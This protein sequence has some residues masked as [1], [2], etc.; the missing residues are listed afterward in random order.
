MFL[1]QAIGSDFDS[2][3]PMDASIVIDAFAASSRPVQELVV[4]LR[5]RIAEE[6]A[7][8]ELTVDYYRIG[9]RL[10]FPLPLD[11]RPQ[12]LPTGIPQMTAYPW[13]TWLFWELE[14]RWRLLSAGWRHLNDEE[15]GRLLQDEVSALATWSHFRG[16]DDNVSLI[17]GHVAAILAHLLSHPSD[18]DANSH[19]QIHATAIDMMERDL[20]PW[21]QCHWA[22]E[23]EFTPVKLHNIA[24]ISLVR[25]AHLA[26]ML[27]HPA[28]TQLEKR[29][30][31]AVRSWWRFRLDDPPHSEGAA[32][33]GY[34]MDHVTEWLFS[35]P[36]GEALFAEGLPAF[37]SL[38]TQWIQLALPG[39]LAESAPLGDV[40]SEMPFWMTVL[41]R[42]AVA[43]AGQVP[44]DQGRWLVQRIAP[45]RLPAAALEW[46]LVN[47]EKL[48]AV[49]SCPSP[50]IQPLATAVTVRTGWE[51]EDLL[52][53]VAAS[54]SPMSHLHNDGGQM[55]LGW[56]G[57][58]WIT[59]PGY[60]QYRPG[61]ERG[62]TI[63]IA[64]HN[65]PVFDDIAQ[66]RRNV[67][68]TTVSE[69]GDSRYHLALD[70]SGCYEGL[71][72]STQIFRDFWMNTEGKSFTVVVRDSFHGLQPGCVIKT[73]WL[74]AADL[75]WSFV[76]NWARLSDGERVLWMGAQPAPFTASQLH[77]HPGSRG[78]L[79]LGH[80][81]TLPNGN[82]VHWWIFQSGHANEWTPSLTQLP[83][84][85]P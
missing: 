44:F 33:D 8:A 69:D 34:L 21:F 27:D 59:D 48:T 2:R 52:L 25:G 24:L 46:L 35:L 77:R 49:P 4:E 76:D 45:V 26:R 62:Y 40:E 11:R 10:S 64:A 30:L 19:Q 53:V 72:A 78:P 28:T 17:T 61:E 65:P 31:D 23:D 36:Q 63:G 60:Q 50:G 83:I 79:T 80:T 38:A 42:L 9:H 3:L 39:D 57:R 7:R 73:H 14:T 43:Y 74:A 13:T 15:A 56:R 58:F 85:S 12:G 68:Q 41:C 82:G 37:A 67:K 5:K 20:L 71:P 16:D 54:R 84:L 55:L 47:Q 81:N 32:Y 66:T 70:M 1:P 75:A 6:K 18:W 29:A 51:R 22:N